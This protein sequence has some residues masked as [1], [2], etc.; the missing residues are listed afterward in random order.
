MT[1]TVTGRRVS[2][3]AYAPAHARIMA[4]A[5]SMLAEALCSMAE[6]AMRRRN[7]RQPR[8]ASRL[9]ARSC[10]AI[11]AMIGAAVGIETW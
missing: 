7:R 3:R 9:A 8:R 2:N 10:V 6:K 11:A 1:S 5:D 4:E